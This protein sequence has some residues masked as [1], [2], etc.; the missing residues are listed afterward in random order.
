M[1][2]IVFKENSRALVLQ[3]FTST[4]I[5]NASN[6]LSIYHFNKKSSAFSKMHLMYIFTQ[7]ISQI[8]KFMIN[9]NNIEERNRK[10]R[11]TPFFM[12]D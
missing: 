3:Y 7:E 8:L 2:I 12:N 11:M 9:H 5:L 1:Q 4:V 6:N 10:L